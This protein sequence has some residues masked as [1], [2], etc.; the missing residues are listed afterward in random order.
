MYGWTRE[1]FAK[2]LAIGND[3]NDG[4]SLDASEESDI[5]HSVHENDIQTHYD[6]N[7]DRN[8]AEENSFVEETSEMYH[9]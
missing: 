5:N 1:D 2:L 8:V 3:R 4:N 9:R 7:I 6:L